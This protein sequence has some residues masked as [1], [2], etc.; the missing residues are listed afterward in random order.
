[1]SHRAVAW[2][3]VVTL[4]LVVIAGYAGSQSNTVGADS[5]AP[6]AASNVGL[7]DA[8][9]RAAVAAAVAQGHAVR[10][11][12][13]QH[14]GGLSIAIDVQLNKDGSSIG[15]V[16]LD[17]AELP[18]RAVG[19]VYYVQMTHGYINRLAEK[20][21][22]WE[23]APAG[24]WI[25]S[26]SGP[27][28]LAADY[29]TLLNYTLFFKMMTSPP[30]GVPVH[31]AGTTTLAGHTVA[32]YTTAQGDKIYVAASGPAYPLLSEGA[33]PNMGGNVTFTWDEPV[34][35]A[36]PLTSDIAR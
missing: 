28:S 24:K 36:A 33:R 10:L 29:A 22:A 5:A 4:A 15:V 9:F 16:T 35:V 14:E 25:T 32:L 17:G 8:Q 19:G 31:S 27:D 11:T 3:L 21:L 34:A 7:S 2:R 13:R 20:N 12:G 23:A 1:M 18:M 30:D 26:Q 6:S